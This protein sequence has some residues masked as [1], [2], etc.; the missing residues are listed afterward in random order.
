[1]QS[2]VYAAQ[3]GA[4]GLLGPWTTTTPINDGRFLHASAFDSKTRTIYVVGGALV[5]CTPTLVVPFVLVLGVVLFGVD[6]DQWRD[7]AT[8]RAKVVFRAFGLE[9]SSSSQPV[10]QAEPPAPSAEL[11]PATRQSQP[12]TETRPI[13]VGSDPSWVRD[14]AAEVEDVAQPG[15]TTQKR[16]ITDLLRKINSIEPD[17]ETSRQALVGVVTRVLDGDTIALR[18][19]SGSH[20]IRLG[21]IDAPESG[22]PGGRAAQRALDKKIDDLRVR[23]EVRTVDRFGRLIGRVYLNERDINREMVAEGHAWAYREY[24]TDRSFLRVEKQARGA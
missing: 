5:C 23:V 15:T 13:A 12:S 6:V 7:T 17:E 20:R 10:E 22:Q 14:A 16:D 18:A 1:M 3:V 21:E 9:S 19:E 24:L 8:D 2:I 11:L 4:D